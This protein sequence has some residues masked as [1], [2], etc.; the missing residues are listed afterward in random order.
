[1]QAATQT[2][3]AITGEEEPGDLTDPIQALAQF[4]RAFN[5]RDLSLMAQNWDNSNDIAMDNPLGGIKRG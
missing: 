1:M 2:Q 4:Y 5:H 3:R